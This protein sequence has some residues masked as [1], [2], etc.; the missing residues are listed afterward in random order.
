MLSRLLTKLP[1]ATLT[2]T[3]IPACVTVDEA[4]ALHDRVG[5][6]DTRLPFLLNT[7][8]PVQPFIANLGQDDADVRFAA[9]GPGGTVM[10]REHDIAV[11]LAAGDGD[12]RA[13]L[14]ATFAGKRPQGLEAAPGQPHGAKANVYIGADPSQWR[15]DL[16]TWAKIRV[17]H[18]FKG[19]GLDIDAT[20]RHLRWS[21]TVATP[22]QA[23]AIR[24]RYDGA[25][26][27]TLAPTGELLVELPV[28][29]AAG[30]AVPGASRTV[31]VEAPRAWQTDKLGAWIPR[32]V[33]FVLQ[34]G[35]IGLALGD[36]APGTP[37]QI[38]VMTGYS[39]F[40][41]AH[42]ALRSDAAIWA[43]TQGEA[44]AG[45]E[46]MGGDIV[47]SRMDA[48]GRAI[49]RVTVLG[50]LASS[51]AGGLG[52]GADGHLWLTGTTAAADF[53]TRKAPRPKLA[54]ET[55]AVL[56]ELDAEGRL[57]R[58]TYWGGPGSDRG[59]D[60]EMDGSGELWLVGLAGEDLAGDPSGLSF[61]TRFPAAGNATQSQF[62]ARID[63]V[64]LTDDGLA[65]LPAVPNPEPGPPPCVL[66]GIPPGPRIRAELDKE[67]RVWV[68]L[69][70][71]NFSPTTTHYEEAGSHAGCSRI[72]EGWGYEALCWKHSISPAVPYNEWSIGSL[73]F[74]IAIDTGGELSLNA[75]EATPSVFAT[76]P[77][78][79]W[80][81]PMN[82][83]SSPAEL[84]VAAALYMH[85]WGSPIYTNLT[86]QSGDN[87]VAAGIH[88]VDF[89][90]TDPDILCDWDG[91]TNDPN[92]PGF[93]T[94]IYEVAR[95]CSF[96]SSMQLHSIQMSTWSGPSWSQTY[97]PSTLYPGTS[98]WHS[99]QHWEHYVGDPPVEEAFMAAHVAEIAQ[100]QS[101]RVLVPLA[102]AKTIYSEGE[103]VDAWV[104]T[105]SVDVRQALR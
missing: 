16:A 59:D 62:V 65:V 15:E 54:G 93:N 46:R 96:N 69:Q 35:E 68:G 49:E 38:E 22:E 29:D 79:T 4:P 81:G 39:R 6:A 75:L 80:E 86:L 30:D 40:R 26:A 74:G 61:A 36:V 95:R 18:P 37:V 99:S 102:V 98:W 13:T 23:T 17:E 94:E 5:A 52:V 103:V 105:E 60:L 100:L 12:G 48:K 97:T 32:P 91:F 63:R 7:G 53:P 78:G 89:N 77:R 66:P 24:W 51:A 9:R 55:D 27:R 85:R 44:P 10:V 41:P 82:A 2:L 19:V 101:H 56:V 71:D 90:G 88:Q 43:E 70:T 76:D 21:F 20:G 57:Q 33:A 8:A 11:A 84:A 104:E 73:A 45:G 67:M 58:S 3:A 34:D 42:D 92:A 31:R 83:A 87:R 64:T 47:V 28:V 50:G 72:S 14:V 25:L 1:L